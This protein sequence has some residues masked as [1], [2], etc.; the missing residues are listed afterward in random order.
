MVRVEALRLQDKRQNRIETNAT[1]RTR[2]ITTTRRMIKIHANLI[3][4]QVE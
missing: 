2:K 4:I 3:H 1:W